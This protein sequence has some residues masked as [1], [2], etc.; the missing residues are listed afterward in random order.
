MKLDISRMIA[1]II[2]QMTYCSVN[3]FTVGPLLYVMHIPFATPRQT[4]IQDVMQKCHNPVCRL[5]YVR[6]HFVPS[7]PHTFPPE[8]LIHSGKINDRGE[9]ILSYR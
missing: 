2:M 8:Y 1:N 5:F 3:V 7:I 6:F 4:S 9:L